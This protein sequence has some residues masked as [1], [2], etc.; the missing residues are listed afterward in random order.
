MIAKPILPGSPLWTLKY[1]RTNLL[2]EIRFSRHS[3]ELAKSLGRQL[4][5]LDRDLRTTSP[6]NFARV[7]AASR[8]AYLRWVRPK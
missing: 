3:R 5:M 2:D 1:V 4:R 8:A 7:V 6:T